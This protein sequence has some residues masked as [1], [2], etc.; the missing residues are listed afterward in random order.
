MSRFDAAELS[1][2]DLPQW[3]A[4]IDQSAHGTIFHKSGWL[5]AC[6]QSLG[7]KVKIFGCFH[8]GQLIGGCSLFLQKKLGVVTTANSTCLTTPYGGCVLSSSPSPNVHKQESFFR[9]I[10]ESL[11][12]EIRKEHFFSVSIQNSPE[13][14][15]IRPFTMHGWRSSV[16]YTYYINLNNN[17]ESNFDSS[18]KRNIRKAEKNRIIIEPF[19]DVSRYYALYCET[20]TRK[21][22][23]P[24]A[25]K[26]LFTE[27]YSFIKN[28]D[29]GEMLA[30][31]TPDD[32]IAC[33]EIVIWD[34]RLGY[35]WTAVS[36]YR[37]L[38]SGAPSLI[39]NDY[40]KRMKDR[41]IP[42]ID[43]MMANIPQL[44]SFATSFNPI[45]VPYYYLKLGWDQYSPGIAP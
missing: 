18:L 9:E 43:I 27:L 21:N 41:G 7:K 39:M 10:I 36:D 44:S 5:D 17:F 13:F 12:S 26:R 11:L 29:C 4:L 3:D 2:A 35:S 45:L 1:R 30:A 20:F 31:K 37:F 14:P 22:L 15:D 23:A 16:Y 33:S 8:D 32:E 34:T 25:P 42:K 38:N 19:S 28:Q 24:P 40:L 6:A